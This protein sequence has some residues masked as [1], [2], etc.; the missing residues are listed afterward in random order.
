MVNGSHNSFRV[1][2]SCAQCT[3][4]MVG[5]LISNAMLQKNEPIILKYGK[6]I[7]TLYYK[8]LFMTEQTQH[9]ESIQDIRQLM[10]KSSRFISLSGLSGI[11]AGA[12]ALVAAWIANN[13]IGQ[14]RLDNAIPGTETGYNYGYGF[15]QGYKNLEQ[16]LILIAGITFVLAFWLAFLF[17]Y[18]RSKKTGVPIWGHVARKVMIHVAV[19]MVAGG[20]VIWRMMEFGLYGFIAPVC[21]IFYGLGLINASKYTFSEIR[22]LGYGQLLLGTLNLW[23]IGYGLTF[24]AVGFGAL[25]IVYGFLMWWKNERLPLT[26]QTGSIH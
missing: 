6:R 13:R 16:E 19:P 12:C 24:W 14:Y 25:H 8:V 1:P 10:Q 7:L 2:K 22:Y 26:G 18:L 5:D 3:G 15:H 21:L 4:S 20:L 11:A 23:L 17:T 9:L